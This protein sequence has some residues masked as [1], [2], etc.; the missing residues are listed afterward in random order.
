MIAHRAAVV[1]PAAGTG[2]R[3]GG[4]TNKLLQ[5]L[6]GEPLLLH[7]LRAVA[8]TGF[9]Q[10][11]LVTR[12][13]ERETIGQLASAA[14]C[15]V[16]F[17][18][19]GPTRQASVAAGLAAVRDDLTLVAVHDGAR[20]GV[21]PALFEAALA[22]AEEH[23]GAVVAV[24]VADTLFRTEDGRLASPVDRDDVWA[25]QTPQA[26][27]LAVLRDAAERARERGLVG[28]DEASLVLAAGGRVQVV[29]GLARNLKI[30][31]RDDF[32]VAEAFQRADEEADMTPLRVGFGY[33]IHPLVAGRECWLGGVL[34]DSPVGLDG[35]SDADVLLHAI[36][37]ALLG[38]AALGDIGR[39]FPNTAAEYHNISSLKLL[40]A[41]DQLVRGAGFHVV[42]VDAT[43]IAE[44][45]KLAPHVPLMQTR[46]AAALSIGETDVSI[47]ATTNERLGSLGASEGI[48]A[49]AVAALVRHKE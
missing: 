36:C 17:A 26:F 18:D 44:Q 39:H 42:N 40:A 9:G 27:R 25:M 10:V 7:T 47:K 23:G 48:A 49:H 28:T 29:E 24:P 1:I 14:G 35:H 20:P 2:T 38:A 3:V 12:P 11:V 15:A 43:V 19:G 37:D 21:T 13:E 34:I 22:A 6:A 31:R 8:A 46:I 5:P 41:T 4:T 32:A 30:T 45:P 16:T 33:D